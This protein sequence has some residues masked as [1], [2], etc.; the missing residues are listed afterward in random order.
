MSLSKLRE[1]VMDREAWRAAVHG[2]AESWTWLSDWTNYLTCSQTLSGQLTLAWWGKE[3]KKRTKVIS[4]WL[5]GLQGNMSR[6]RYL[7][8]QRVFR[9]GDFRMAKEE[10]WETSSMWRRTVKPRGSGIN[11]QPT[12]V[13][14]APLPHRWQTRMVEACTST[15]FICLLL[16]QI[17]PM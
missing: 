4:Q 5:K 2:V 3:H 15:C 12:S 9:C 17:L 10:I 13:L 6:K 14:T 16:S 1:L 8:P 7:L 11:G